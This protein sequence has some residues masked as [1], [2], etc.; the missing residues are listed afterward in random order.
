MAGAL[1]ARRYQLP[2]AG[3][4]RL[5]DDPRGTR[6]A[7][8]HPSR[9]GRS[10]RQL[11]RPVPES[12]G[13][14][15]TRRCAPPVPPAVPIGRPTMWR[16]RLAP[17]LACRITEAARHTITHLFTQL[18]G[19]RQ[20][21][22]SFPFCDRAFVLTEPISHELDQQPYSPCARYSAASLRSATSKRSARTQAPQRDGF[23]N[24]EARCTPHACETSPWPSPSADAV[25]DSIVTGKTPP[26]GTSG[27]GMAFT[28]GWGRVVAAI[29]SRWP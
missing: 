23:P 2:P 4:L 11:A 6:H 20:E 15:K 22:R 14:I 18:A 10:R 21:L 5:G 27:S 24:D 28:V 3:A 9:T 29:R 1:H 25:C 17:A 12:H 26:A 16:P 19:H 13:H 7:A 8:H